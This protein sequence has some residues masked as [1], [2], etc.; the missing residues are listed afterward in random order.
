MILKKS[1]V[2]RRKSLKP[3]VSINWDYKVIIFFIIFVCGLIFGITIIKNTDK[4][5]SQF[6]FG[7]LKRNLLALK[8]CNFLNNACSTFL[9][10]FLTVFAVFIF[11]QCSIG[12]A[13]VSLVPLLWGV[14]TGIGI[15]CYYSIYNFNGLSYFAIINLPFYAITAATII[16]GCCISTKMSNEIFLSLLTDERK[17]QENNAF[18]QYCLTYLVLLIPLLLSALLK[19]SSYK[20]FSDLFNLV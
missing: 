2:I 17:K 5:T 6:L 8:G 1:V 13:F 19:A 20:L 7:I 11:G 10:S 18:K 16:K 9:L 4:N 12:V 14:F 3:I 15:S